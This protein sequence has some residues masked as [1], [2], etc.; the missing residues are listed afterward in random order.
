MRTFDE[1]FSE[2]K[3]LRTED[4]YRY[5]DKELE[6]NRGYFEDCYKQNLSC[7]LCLEILWFEIN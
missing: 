5:T 7:Y 4:N 6:E 1:Y 2:V 3:K